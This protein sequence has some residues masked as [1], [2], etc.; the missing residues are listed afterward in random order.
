[1]KTEDILFSQHKN[2]SLTEKKPMAFKDI[3]KQAIKDALE[4]NHG[5]ISEAA[6]EL[7]LSRQT[8]YN[9]IVKYKL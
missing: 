4:N 6:K 8:V 1:L 3:E 5:N 7:G 2:T 9:K